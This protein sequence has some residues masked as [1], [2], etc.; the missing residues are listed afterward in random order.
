MPGDPVRGKAR[1]KFPAPS[2]EEQREAM[3]KIASGGKVIVERVVSGNDTFGGQVPPHRPASLTASH[4]AVLL[5]EEHQ[6]H[7]ARIKQLIT[8]LHRTGADK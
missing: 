8:M 1:P 4:I 7:A 6:R 5:D 3:T 2:Y